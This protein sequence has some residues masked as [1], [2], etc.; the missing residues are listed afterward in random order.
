ME[1]LKHNGKEY[2]V[3]F[4]T[5]IMIQMLEDAGFTNVVMLGSNQLD[6]GKQLAT[7][8]KVL[9]WGV[10]GGYQYQEV[11]T[12]K[13]SLAEARELIWELTMTDNP[14]PNGI[15]AKVLIMMRATFPTANGES[16]EPEK[17]VA[18]SEKKN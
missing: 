13:L 16:E 4:S 14:D 7:S 18:E 15:M 6:L 3:H 11:F 5:D 9:Y 1:I 2:P 8:A 10:K 17:E 12:E